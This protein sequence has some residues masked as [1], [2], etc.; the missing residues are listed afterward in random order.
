MPREFPGQET[1]TMTK[2]MTD[3]VTTEAE[4]EATA[5]SAYGQDDPSFFNDR[6]RSGFKNKVRIEC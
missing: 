4:E 5:A 1:F 6:I 3:T 2:G